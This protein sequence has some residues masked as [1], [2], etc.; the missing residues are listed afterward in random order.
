MNIATNIEGFEG[1]KIEA[2][3]SIWSRPKLFVNGELAPKGAGT[4]E[5]I[6]QRN[7]GRQVTA[8]WKPQALGFEIPQLVVDGRPLSWLRH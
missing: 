4:G 3:V 8:I 6:L 5:I 7:D 1:Q 2:Q